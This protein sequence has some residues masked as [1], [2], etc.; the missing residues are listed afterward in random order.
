MT[1]NWYAARALI[2]KQLMDSPTFKR[3]IEEAVYRD[4]KEDDSPEKYS[5]RNIGA[6]GLRDC[7][8]WTWMI[9][10]SEFHDQVMR[11]NDAIVQNTVSED[12]IR[13]EVKTLSNDIEI[14]FMSLPGH[15]QHTP[16][17]WDRHTKCGF[18]RE[19]TILQLNYHHQ[20]QMLYYQFLKKGS[21]T[22]V[23]SADQEAE[24]YAEKCK[25]HATALSQ[26]MWNANSCAGME[27]TWSPINGHL[28]VVSSSVLIYSLLFD[29][30][31]ESIIRAKKLLEQNFIM[32]LQ[33]RR[34]WALVEL[35][36]ARL[37]AF[38]KAC[39]MN[40][41][42]QNFDM[43]HW[44]VYFLNR[45]DANVSERYEDGIYGSGI[46]DT[47][48]DLSPMPDYLWLELSENIATR[49]HS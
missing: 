7:G 8:L 43:D 5:E 32:L 10:L 36:M 29:T 24:R 30:D 31:E 35:S 48:M 46:S 16:E 6:S 1:E 17:N 12:H 3:P 25:K 34:Y 33:L 28:L 20:C 41:T 15:L 2:P 44:M 40:S 13:Q 14:Y 37:R 38:H 47:Y 4:M 27:C 42:Q 23:Y 11:L 19:F 26:V 49:S 22:S 21:A 45:Y 39:Q 9:P 18:G